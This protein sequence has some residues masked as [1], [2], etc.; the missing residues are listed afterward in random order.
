MS[1]I[2][3]RD[4]EL[5]IEGHGHKAGVNEEPAEDDDDAE[6]EAHVM[7]MPNVRMD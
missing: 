7:K 2:E 5:E 6:F 1:D 3:N 4:E